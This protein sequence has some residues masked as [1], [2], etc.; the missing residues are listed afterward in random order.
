[1]SNSTLKI[2]Q[3]VM[4]LLRVMDISR[5]IA[6]TSL[7]ELKLQLR[8]GEKEYKLILDAVPLEEELNKELMELL[9]A[10]DTVPQVNKVLSK[11]SFHIEQ[12][13]GGT[14]IPKGKTTIVSIDSVK[15]KKIPEKGKKKK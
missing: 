1:M 8:K 3:K 15:I 2:D 10:K 11:D 9:F 13:K 5:L 14:P 12:S 4:E 6:Y 7:G